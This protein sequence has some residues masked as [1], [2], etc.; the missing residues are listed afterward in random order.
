[1]RFADS[2]CRYVE[3]F[4]P[5]VYSYTGSCVISG[6]KITVDVPAEGLYKYRQGVLIQDAFPEMSE[7]DREFLM[8]GICGEAFDAAFEE[9]N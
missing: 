1:M 9:N 7:D 4:N 6:K 8:S 2:E 5:H 3:K